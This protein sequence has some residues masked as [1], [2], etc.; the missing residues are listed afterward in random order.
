MVDHPDSVKLYID[1]TFTPPP[2]KPFKIF[3]VKKKFLPI[4]AKDDN[5]QDILKKE[6]LN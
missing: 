3:I 6:L 4:S 5:D 2:F 1:E